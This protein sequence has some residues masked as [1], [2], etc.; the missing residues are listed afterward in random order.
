M[1][2]EILLERDGRNVGEARS[3]APPGRDAKI[4]RFGRQCG[5]L[6]LPA[7]QGAGLNGWMLGCN[8]KQRTAQTLALFL[9]LW[10]TMQ[11]CAGDGCVHLQ[12]EAGGRLSLLPRHCNPDVACDAQRQHKRQNF[13][14]VN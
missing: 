8:L 13:N 14:G 7:S 10:E 1:G 12:K 5:R 4:H 2:G 3:W 9:G 6:F 11:G